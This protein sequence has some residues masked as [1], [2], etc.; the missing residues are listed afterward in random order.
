[1]CGH[2]GVARKRVRVPVSGGGSLAVQADVCPHCGEQYFDLETMRKIEAADQPNT[3]RSQTGT[4]TLRTCI[5]CGS[6]KVSRRAVNVK[7]WVGKTVR[8]NADVCPVCGER[9]FDLDAMRA[10]E[11]TDPRFRV[12][13]TRRSKTDSKS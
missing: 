9:Y 5:S 4:G 8:V 1:M 11:A 2:R 7:L 10:L 13:K 6:K 3:R 12:R